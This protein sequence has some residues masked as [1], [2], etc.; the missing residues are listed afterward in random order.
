MRYTIDALAQLPD[1]TLPDLPGVRRLSVEAWIKYHGLPFRL[2]WKA[3]AR[4]HGRQRNPEFRLLE[5]LVP[6]DRAA[7][8][9]GGNFGLVTYFLARLAPRV[10]ACEPSPVPLPSLRRLVDANVTVWPVAVSDKSGP[11]DLTVW[12]SRRGWTTNGASLA[13]DK[14]DHALAHPVPVTAVA[15]DDIDLPPIGFIKI[16]VEGHE[17]AVLEGAKATLARHRPVLMVENEN[18]HVGPDGVAAV[19]E[20]MRAARYRIYGLK[21]G[22]LTDISRFDVAAWQAETKGQ[23]GRYVQNFIGLPTD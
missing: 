5:H 15:L 3:R 10:F 8:D 9:V 19:F 12:Q 16:D 11:I 2:G 4:R 1:P 6:R 23:P 7:I 18:H 14:R 20:S 13:E 22:A 17:A 21:D